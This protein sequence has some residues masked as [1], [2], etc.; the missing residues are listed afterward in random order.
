MKLGVCY[1]PEHWPEARWATD[2]AMMRAAGLEIVR[3]A[4]FAWARMEPAEEQYAW[5]WLDRAIDVLA[6]A[7]LQ[8]VLGTPTA[9]PPAWLSRAHPEILRVDR[10][11]RFRNHGSR[12]HYCPNSPTY[13]RY[14]RRIV[15][16]M[17]ERYGA[18]ARVIGWQIDNEFGGGHTARC[19][20]RNCAAAFREWLQARY[21]TIDALNAAWGA[22]FWSQTYDDW[23][24]IHPPD[25][26]IDKPNPSQELDYFRFSSDAYVAYQQQQIDILR[27]HAPGRFITH[28][29]MGLYRDLNQFDLAAPLDF[30]S[31][32]NY[33]TGNAD[34]WRPLLYP[35]GSPDRVDPIYAYDVGDPLITGM[36]H[37]LTYGLKQRPFWIMEQQPGAINW[38]TLNPGVRPGTVRLWTWH[39]LAAG[40]DACVYFRW[41]PTLFAQEQYHSGLLRHDA[42]PATGYHD[43]LA[44]Q[45][46]RELMAAVAAAPAAAEVA[47]LFD[48]DDLW[49]IQL[50]PHRHDFDYLRHL[51]VYYTALLRLGISVDLVSLQSD[52]SRYKLL[53]APSLHIAG[54][55]RA[56]LLAEFVARGG[57]L[58]LGV[59]SGFKTP[60]NLVTDRPLPGALRELAGVTVTG[61]QALPP[62][63]ALGV[64]TAVPHLTGPATYWVESLQADTARALGHYDNGAVAL[65]EMRV[66]P[67]GS[68]GGNG[69]VFTLGWYPT[70]DQAAAL[71]R[72]LAAELDVAPAADLPPG[73]LAYR[74]GPYTILL[75]FTEAPLE[76]AVEGRPLVV[77]ARDV[78]VHPPAP[79]SA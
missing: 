26:A 31:W 69:R 9:T 67:A 51:F 44:L 56:R 68:A 43:V 46:E 75:N 17:A 34:R 63:V 48:F 50:E 60:S 38:G 49:A 25:D 16:A 8:I 32:D 22:V 66:A 71:L 76:T 28:N 78:V 12:R 20:C 45:T 73:L 64:Q 37:A 30:V 62:D 18:D 6:G 2:A 4:E 33:P 53:V 40:A 21:E 54:A 52:L 13:R 10:D 77:P 74:R 29:F 27:A 14:S 42:E 55:A 39:A 70:A 5:A 3:I 65:A 23:L 1:Y 19:Y 41:R 59:R 15:Q 47:L 7:G 72:Y 24:Q 11:G 57:A 79:P 35:P 61:W 36:A 58:L